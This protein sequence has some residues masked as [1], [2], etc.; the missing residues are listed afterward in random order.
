MQFKSGPKP[1]NTITL[2]KKMLKVSLKKRREASFQDN[3]IGRIFTIW[4]PFLN[5]VL[6]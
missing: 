5:Y 1:K 2:W 3:S 4:N 6:S